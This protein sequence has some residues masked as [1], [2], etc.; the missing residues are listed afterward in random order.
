[1]ATLQ[2]ETVHVKHQDVFAERYYSLL[3]W[4]CRVAGGDATLAQDL[5]HD[6]YV[7]FLL[8]RPDLRKIQSVD[9]YLYGM[10][11]NLH[12][13]YLRRASRTQVKPLVA[14]RESRRSWRTR[15]ITA[16]RA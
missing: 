16:G 4:A 1:M 10:L 8:A 12:I 3:R 6:G 11:Q 14:S 7:Q 2:L 9:R 5:V 13:S 15:D